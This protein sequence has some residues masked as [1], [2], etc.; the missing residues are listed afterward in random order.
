[1]R[2]LL[3]YLPWQKS[4]GMVRDECRKNCGVIVLQIAE[5]ET[6]YVEMPGTCLSWNFIQNLAQED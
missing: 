5:G 4:S 1:M 2:K 3:Y 6:R